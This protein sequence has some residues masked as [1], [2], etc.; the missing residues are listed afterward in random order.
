MVSENVPG[1]QS[2]QPTDASI[3][4][5]PGVQSIHVEDPLDVAD[6]PFGH[7]KHVPENDVLV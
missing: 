3:E 1:V 7:G 6:V 2:M 4:N 5:R